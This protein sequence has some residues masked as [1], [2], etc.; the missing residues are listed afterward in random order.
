MDPSRPSPSVPA[1]HRRPALRGHRHGGA[2]PRRGARVRRRVHRGGRVPG[3]VRVPDHRPALEA[4]CTATDRIGFAVVL[5]PPGPADPARVARWSSWPPRWWPGGWSRRSSW[6]SVTRDGL[7]SALFVANIRFAAGPHQLPRRWPPPSAFQQYWS[8]GRGGAVL[9]GV[10]GGAA[11]RC[12]GTRRLGR[13]LA[14]PGPGR[15]G[16]VEP[17][18]VRWPSWWL[19][20]V[21]Q[22]WAFFSLPTRAWELGAGALLALGQPWLK[23][24]RPVGGGPGAR[25]DRPG[26]PWPGPPPGCR[27]ATPYPGLAALIPVAG[28][29]AVIAAGCAPSRLGRRVAARDTGR[30]APAGGCPTRLYLWHWPILVLVPLAVG[31]ACRLAANLGLVR[32]G[33]RLCRR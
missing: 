13:P 18:V 23:Q 2:V 14:G 6:R 32:G 11:V 20:G 25:V 17:G 24:H 15:A 33:H 1:R 31:H 10:A 29:A 28:T 27:A 22:P 21:N 7:A 5:R 8:L 19:T 16:R 9:P 4:S 30:S 12:R 3:P 26:W